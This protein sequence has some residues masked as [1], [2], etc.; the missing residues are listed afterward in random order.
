MFFH[1]KFNDNENENLL[2]S[3]HFIPFPQFV[4]ID[5][6]IHGT[7]IRSSIIIKPDQGLLNFHSTYLIKLT[8]RI[9]LLKLFRKLCPNNSFMLKILWINRASNS[10]FQ[11]FQTLPISCSLTRTFIVFTQKEHWMWSWWCKQ[12]R[13]WQDAVFCYDTE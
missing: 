7:G 4:L 6:M 5:S 3:T 2:L 13:P 11:L 9:F 1:N 12:C 10:P 8:C